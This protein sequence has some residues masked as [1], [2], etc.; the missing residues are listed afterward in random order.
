MSA[1]LQFSSRSTNIPLASKLTYLS[2]FNTNILIE[3]KVYIE[4]I[5]FFEV[6]T[7]RYFFECV[8]NIRVFTFVK[9]LMF[10]TREMKCI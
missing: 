6:S 5:Y 1:K 7:K 8:E 4:D 2:L 9:T 3:T 10:S